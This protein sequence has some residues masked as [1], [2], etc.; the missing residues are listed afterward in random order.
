MNYRLENALDRLPS[1]GRGRAYLNPR[2]AE[3]GGFSEKP[4]LCRCGEGGKIPLI[5]GAD[6][7]FGR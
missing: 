1:C 6:G 4:S 7:P 2:Q 3:P 5:S